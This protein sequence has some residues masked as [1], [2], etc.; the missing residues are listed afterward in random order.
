MTAINENLKMIR[1]SKGLRQEDVARELGVTRQIISSYESNR[2]QADIETLKQLAIIYDVEF[3]D[4]LYGKNKMQIKHKTIKIIATLSIIVLFFCNLVQSII[5]WL[6]NNYFIVESGDIT[7]SFHSIINVRMS[8]LNIRSA[9]GG[10]SSF[11]FRLLSIILFLLIITLERPIG[12]SSK[13]KYLAILIIASVITILP[14]SFFDAI[15]TLFDYSYT[16][17]LN[18]IF[19]IILLGLTFVGE[20]IV[21]LYRAKLEA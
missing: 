6:L 9:I 11:S 14:W 10:L 17:I 16:A 3:N 19:A 21:R 12:T 15:Y 13:L 1:K 4:I 18:L 7:N 20:Y 8:A 5:L 2:T